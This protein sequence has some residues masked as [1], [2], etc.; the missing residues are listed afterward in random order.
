MDQQKLYKKAKAVL[1]KNDLGT[2]T[3][4]ASGLY[5]HQWLWDSCF[6]AIGLRHIDPE[7]AKD[8]IRSILGGQWKN[9]MIPHIIFSDAKGY[10]AGPWLW[11]SHVSPNAPSHVQTTGITQPPILGEAIVRI[12]EILPSAERI[13]WY[14]EVFEPLLRYHEWL[15]RE[16]DPKGT[17][18]VTV[19]HPWETGMDNTPPWME[20]LRKKAGI[21]GLLLLEKIG[22]GRFIDLFRQDTHDVPAEERMSTHDLY[23]VYKIVR[24]LHQLEYDNSK[25]LK[26][27]KVLVQ[28]LAF[29]SILQKA[30]SHLKDIASEL[31]KPLPKNLLRSMSKVSGALENCWDEK[32]NNYYSLDY[33]TGKPIKVPSIATL[34]PIYGDKLNKEKL[35]CLLEHLNPLSD[36]SSPFGIPSAPVSSK[37]FNAHR[38]WQGPVW[39]NMNWLLIQGLRSNGCHKEA[40]ELKNNTLNLVEKAGMY[41]Y[42]SPLDGSPAGIC[43]FSW[44]AAL[45]LD[46]LTEDSG[47]EGHA[48]SSRDAPNHLEHA[49]I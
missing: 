6:I 43:D 38:Y 29:N 23:A 39:I 17:G 19:V 2:W 41:E 32:S 14:E 34:L 5:P 40:A 42:F 10:H 15:Y 4:P 33:C 45:V 12:G 7:R 49:M 16:R 35:D 46:L 3:Q 21:N 31:D 25:I 37:F 24:Q 36:F 11:N 8:E 9:G 13:A 44:T 20:I 30:N 22:L 28:D 47:Q 26:K 48:A 1:K 27:Q 18:L